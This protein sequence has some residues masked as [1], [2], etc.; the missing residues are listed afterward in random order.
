MFFTLFLFMVILPGETMANDNLPKKV[1]SVPGEYV[2][3][4][5]AALQEVDKKGF[6]I[7]KGNMEVF[8]SAESVTVVFGVLGAPKPGVRGNPSGSPILEIEL[9]KST[10]EVLRTNYVR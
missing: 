10:Y 7:G 8:D 4:V 2:Q 9:K 6:H 3:A 5:R 1:V